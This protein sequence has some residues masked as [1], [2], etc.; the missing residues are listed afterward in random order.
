RLVAVPEAPARP[1]DV[2]IRKIVDVVLVEVDHIVREEALVRVG[3]VRDE[4]M[5]ALDEPAIER[6]Q[7]ARRLE[8]RPRRAKTLDVRVR[9]E[10]RHRVPESQQLA[11]YFARGT[12]AEK[13]IA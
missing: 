13:Q 7:L 4:R 12:E 3:R 1:A 9:D 11:L 2:P 10:E 8:R 5:R 6:L